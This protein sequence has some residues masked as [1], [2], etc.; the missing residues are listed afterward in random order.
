MSIA[1]AAALMAWIVTDDWL[2]AASI[3]TLG[4]IWAFLRAREGPPVLALAMSL[5]WVQVTIG[6]FYVEVTRRPLPT[7]LASEYRPMVAIGLACVGVLAAGLWCGQRVVD[8]FGPAERR[9][10]EA[11]LT[12]T[13]LQWAY[14]IAVAGFGV[15]HESAWSYPTIT[16]AIIAMTYVRLGLL[17]L[18]LRQLVQTCRWHFVALLLCFEV[19]L[20]FTGFYAGFREPLVMA[21][22]ALLEIFDRRDIRHWVALATL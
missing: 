10:P 14:G 22:L 6:L 18:L 9:R 5:Q 21:A 4:A 19:A 11:A 17:Y 16:Q 7:T 2:P 20:G 12:C 3:F 1:A 8:R 13:M 15:V